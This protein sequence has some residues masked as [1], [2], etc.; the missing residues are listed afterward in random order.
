[1]KGAVDP[2]N[3]DGWMDRDR[4]RVRVVVIVI[5]GATIR[6]EEFDLG[7]PGR[8]GTR[9]PSTSPTSPRVWSGHDER[10]EAMRRQKGR[11]PKTKWAEGSGSRGKKG[12]KRTS[13]KA[14]AQ[15]SVS[16]STASTPSNNPTALIAHSNITSLASHLV[17]PVHLAN[18]RGERVILGRVL[19]VPSLASNL[20]SVS[21][22]D[23]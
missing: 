3:E 12:K 16:I 14:N 11:V 21:R 2:L 6:G 17:G 1:M 15:A 18:H 7:W 9:R 5:I 8:T 23:W 19:Y 20:L 22:P 13:Q 10:R 4:G